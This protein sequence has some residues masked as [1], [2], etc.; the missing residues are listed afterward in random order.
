[1]N[2]PLKRILKYY[3]AS[4]GFNKSQVEKIREVESELDRLKVDYYSPFKE[5][6]SFD[7]TKS[8]NLVKLQVKSIFDKNIY[9]LCECN[10]LIA[11]VDDLDKGTLFE[12]GYK[13]AMIQSERLN[14]SEYIL[15]LGNLADQISSELNSQLPLDHNAEMEG[16]VSKNGITVIDLT[17]KGIKEYIGLGIRFYYGDHIYSWSALPMESNIMTAACTRCHECE[18][19]SGITFDQYLQRIMRSGYYDLREGYSLSSLNYSIKVD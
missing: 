7:F 5:G 19:D 6:D 2:N 17:N 10:H 9:Q 16:R 18:S 14:P 13:A 11:L 12:I 15:L 4:P 3:I 8:K 1:M